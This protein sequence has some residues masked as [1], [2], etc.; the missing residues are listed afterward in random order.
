MAVTNIQ[1]FLVINQET[2]DLWKLNRVV[3][4]E[5]NVVFNKDAYTFTIGDGI[6]PYGNLTGLSLANSLGYDP[7]I[8]EDSDGNLLWKGSP[9]TAESTLTYVHLQNVPN[10]IWNIVHNYHK[11]PISI[12]VFDAD[13]L[14]ITAYE[15]WSE[16]TDNKFVLRFGIAVAGK[17]ILTF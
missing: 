8:T 5:G 15:S 14:K 4:S 10:T 6:S 11:Q 9:V 13:N 1:G 3:I 2:E 16:S 12:T 7:R 17:A